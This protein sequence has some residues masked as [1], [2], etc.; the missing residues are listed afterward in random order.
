[1]MHEENSIE[2]DLRKPLHQKQE[3]S[4]ECT[5]ELHSGIRNLFQG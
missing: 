5:P 3:Q 2:Q 1:M 4:Y